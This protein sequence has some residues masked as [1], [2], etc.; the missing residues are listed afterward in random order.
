M[1]SSSNNPVIPD[2]VVP[3]PPTPPVSLESVDS[4][5]VSFRLPYRCGYGHHL[6]V[7]G[8]GYSLGNWD[9]Q[10]R[11]SLTWSEGDLWTA[12]TALSPETSSLEYKFIICDDN[13]N[14]VKWQPGDNIK[15]AMPTGA[16]EMIVQN[17]WDVGMREERSTAKVIRWADK[18]NVS[19]SQRQVLP[20]KDLKR[21]LNSH[22]SVMRKSADPTSLDAILADRKLA[23]ALDA[24]TL[25]LSSGI[26][27]PP[28]LS[29]AMN[30]HSMM[31]TAEPSQQSQQSQQGQQERRDEHASIS[32]SVPY[33]CAFGE[34]L[35]VVGKGELLGDWNIHKRIQM[36]WNEGDV[37]QALVP[38]DPRSRH[39]EYK[40]VVC[41][42]GGRVV[43]WQPGGN[44][45]IRVPSSLAC[46]PNFT[47]DLCESFERPQIVARPR[48][49]TSRMIG[50]LPRK[51]SW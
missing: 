4:P 39:L 38:V 23:E 1:A 10:N 9:P 3:P 21:S 42:E 16:L 37:W 40:Y 17:A 7:V 15:V 27:D 35:A 19:K 51:R 46:D 45:Q 50:D 18:R 31:S 49:S 14:P 2:P 34:H 8:T 44:R 5:T 11:V 24:L 22:H 20:L 29:Q 30:S 43:Q 28:S 48:P 26:D 12:S 13:G 41:G 6:A 32:L 25:A 33:T 36:T 47:M